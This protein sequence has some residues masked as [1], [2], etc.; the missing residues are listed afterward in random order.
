M[1]KILYNNL[2]PSFDICNTNKDDGLTKHE[3]HGLA[4]QEFIQSVGGDID[5]GDMFFADM[6]ADAN[7]AVS[8]QEFLDF[9]NAGQ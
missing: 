6:D 4:C 9:Y 3:L 2:V 1:S 5:A 7:G 8:K